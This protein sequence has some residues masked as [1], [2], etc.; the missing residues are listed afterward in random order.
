MPKIQRFET[1]V[2]W[3]WYTADISEEQA[4]EY[5]K[6]EEGEIDEP[7]WVYDLEYDL[8]KDKPGSD[9]VEYELID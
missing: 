4:E 6:Y 3:L 2:N 9:E 7:D 1:Q 5:R 8:I